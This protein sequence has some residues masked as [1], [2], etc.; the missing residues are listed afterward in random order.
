MRLSNSQMRGTAIAALLSLPLAGGTALAQESQDDT[1]TEQ[2]A[3]ASQDTEQQQSTTGSGQASGD[4]QADAVVAK[5]GEAEIRGSDVMTVIGML[6]QQM[7]SQPPQVLMPMAL[8]QLILRELII[9]EARSQNLGNDPEVKALV[10]DSAQKAEEDAMVQIWLAR[11][12]KGAVTD[13]AVQKAY[14]D[15]KAEG[16]QNLPP[17]DEVRPQIEQ[18]LRQEAMQE[19]KTQLRQDGADV[20]LLDAAGQPKQQGGGMQDGQGGQGSDDSGSDNTSASQSEG[21]MSSGGSSDNSDEQ[22]QSN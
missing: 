9:E 1:E 3:T 15:A 17:V 11:E 6:P 8:E 12:M 13:D 19:I 7:Q 20:V 16:A 5:V 4:M 2:S 14:D 21:G 22:S 18:Q 10:E